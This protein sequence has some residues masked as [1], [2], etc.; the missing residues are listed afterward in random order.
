MLPKT[1]A[2]RMKVIPK[3]RSAYNIRYLRLYYYDS[4]DTSVGGQLVP[5]G[6]IRAVV[7]VYGT[8]MVC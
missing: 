1:N 8:D 5:K 7:S 2:D 3:K 4:A 6:I